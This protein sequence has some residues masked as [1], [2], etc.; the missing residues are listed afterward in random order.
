LLIKQSRIGSAVIPKS[1]PIP[2]T[3]PAEIERLI[4]GL[5]QSNLEQRDLELVE[6]LLQTVLSLVRLLQRV[7]SA[8]RRAFE[9]KVCIG[10]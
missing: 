3:D 4:E 1:D 5:R 8:G 2:K 7:P 9:K 10:R 6:R